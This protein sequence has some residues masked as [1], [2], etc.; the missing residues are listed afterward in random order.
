VEKY[1]EAVMFEKTL[2]KGEFFIDRM[3]FFEKYVL[4]SF[5]TVQY[6]LLIKK[7]YPRQLPLLLRVV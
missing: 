7:I 4:V 2:D 3:A 6:I 5:R 1:K